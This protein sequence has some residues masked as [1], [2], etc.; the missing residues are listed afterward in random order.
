M[1]LHLVVVADCR[2]ALITFSN[3]ETRKLVFGFGRFDLATHKEAIQLR[4][5]TAAFPGQG[6]ATGFALQLAAE[7]V[8][9]EALAQP[10]SRPVV[11]L[12]TDGETLESRQTFMEGAKALHKTEAD[13]FAVGVASD[14]LNDAGLEGLA[15]SASSPAARFVTLAEGYGSLGALAESLSRRIRDRCS[16]FEPTTTP[17]T[18]A[19][20]TTTST[21]T[22]TG[23]TTTTTDTGST[24][25]GSTTTGTGS[26]TTGTDTTIVATTTTTRLTTTITTTSPTV[27][28][29]T[30]TS[31]TD[32]GCRLRDTNVVL[33]L[34]S[35]TSITAPGWEETIA[36]GAQL[37]LSLAQLTN[38]TR[39]V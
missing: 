4:I 7:Q 24:G 12:V 30:T 1:S 16:D 20:T 21:I 39:Y 33:V 31:T 34:D 27:T 32:D 29:S 6:T 28:T 36:A 8:Q 15:I 2:V 38:I 10:N 26:T 17:S 5:Q 18:T 3:H 37:L 19:T 13:V 11:V 23:S 35:S 25:T 22:D 9:K 14:G